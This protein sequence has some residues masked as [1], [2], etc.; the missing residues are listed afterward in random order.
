MLS[1]LQNEPAVAGVGTTRYGKLPGHDIYE[2]AQWAL[3]EALD[4][5]GLTHAD[6]D[7]LIVNRIPSYS[8]FADQCG[9]N[10]QYVLATP[11][12]GRFSGI[13]IQTAALLVSSGAVNTVALVYANDGGSAGITYGGDASQFGGA[14]GAYGGADSHWV[15]YG[16]TSPGAFHALMMQRHM[17]LH[18]TT[19]SQ[20]AEVAMTF[21]HHASLNPAAVK[22]DPFTLEQYLE[23]RFICD[24]LRLLDYCLINDGAV[25]MIITNGSRARDL[26]K[27][28]VYIRGVGQASQFTGGGFP[29]DDFWARPMRQ[30]AQEVHS[31]A[32]TTVNDMDGLMIYDNFTPTVLFSLEGFGF[33][34]T[35]ES[36]R[37]VSEGHLRLGGRFPANTSGGHLSESYLQGWGLNAEAVRQLRGEC[38]ARQIAGADFIQYMAASPV[39][40]SIIY[41][42]DPK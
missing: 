28:P 3:R 11:G 13:C 5:C 36:G 42:K 6:L 37:W 40:T 8:H 16:M 12:H 41:G 23:S 19:A 7:G 31:M 9:M 18:G 25:A 27:P 15:P 14:A 24:P 35:G 33:C 34:P 4:D 26:R 17:H 10:P 29:P 30:V 32:G 20:L 1:K 38:D 21:R 39:V 2:L 22:R